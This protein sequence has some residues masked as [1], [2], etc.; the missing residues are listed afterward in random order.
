MRASRVRPN[1]F[2]QR[3]KIRL[4]DLRSIR[5]EMCAAYRAAT[6]RE[7]DWQDLRAAIACLSAIASLDQGIGVDARL[8]EIEARLAAIKPNGAAREARL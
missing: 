1:L 5:A 6:R 2:Y 7:V 8:G 3:Q 4:G